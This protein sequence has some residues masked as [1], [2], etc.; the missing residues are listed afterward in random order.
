MAEA[1]GGNQRQRIAALRMALEAEPTNGRLWNTL[2]QDLYRT[3]ETDAARRALDMSR[4]TEPHET[5]TIYERVFV[6]LLM[7]NDLPVERRQH[8]MTQLE[9]IRAALG[10]PEFRLLKEAIAAKAPATREELK[11]MIL[12]TARGDLRLIS[13]LDL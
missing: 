4:L 11:A 2:S 8:A 3:G 6:S 9:E 5:R 13:A 10:P 12:S 1:P 7:W